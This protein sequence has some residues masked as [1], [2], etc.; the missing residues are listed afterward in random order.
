[1]HDR[2]EPPEIFLLF[3][4]GSLSRFLRVLIC[5]RLPERSGREQK[6]AGPDGFLRGLNDRI[7]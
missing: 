7:A 4:T 1:M 3:T 2:S 6:R 5:V